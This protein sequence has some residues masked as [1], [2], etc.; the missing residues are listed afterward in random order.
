M[1][2]KMAILL[3]GLVALCATGCDQGE[4]TFTSSTGIESSYASLQISPESSNTN[5]ST[6]GTY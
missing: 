1:F 4:N 3:A 5:Q 2:K 6:K